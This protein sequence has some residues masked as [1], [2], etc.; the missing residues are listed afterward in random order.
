[1]EEGTSGR[2]RTYPRELPRTKR[3]ERAR[4]NVRIL[5]ESCRTR[6][7]RI[8]S[9]P[10][11]HNSPFSFEIERKNFFHIRG[12]IYTIYTIYDSDDAS[13]SSASPLLSATPSNSHSSSRASFEISSLAPRSD[14]RRSPVV[15]ARPTPAA[16]PPPRPFAVSSSASAPFSWPWRS[17]RPARPSSS[18]SLLSVVVDVASR[19]A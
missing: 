15:G 17:R 9:E 6:P 13:P 10:R 11:T 14:P 3:R 5:G 18:S 2:S 8:P 1:M 16:D 7:R 4:L 12:L 19:C